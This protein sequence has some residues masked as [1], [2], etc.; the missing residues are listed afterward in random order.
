[1]AQHRD[2][3][4]DTFLAHFVASNNVQLRSRDVDSG[5]K[6]W[7]SRLTV[8][9]PSGDTVLVDLYL[10]VIHSHSRHAHEYRFQGPAN[11]TKRAIKQR[12]NIIP[13]I[14][15]ID[16]SASPHI[17]VAGNAEKYL[18]RDQRQTVLFDVRILD[19]V[20][21]Q[22][23]A[24]YHSSTGETIHSFLPEFFPVFVDMVRQELNLPVYD[25]QRTLR[26][27]GYNESTTKET[28]ERVT[29]AISR[30]LRD[31]KF[32][33]EVVR[34]YQGRCA[35]SDINWGVVQAAHIFPVAA[36]GSTDRISNGIGLTPT[37][38]SLFDRHLIYISPDDLSVRLHP[39]LH[40]DKTTAAREFLKATRAIL[41]VPSN[42]SQQPDPIM[43]KNRY[44]Y[45][46]DAYS[47]ALTPAG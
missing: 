26:D 3:H 6:A 33:K 8:R 24:E 7:P 10:G 12:N 20:R 34:A 9:L 28:R 4:L 31:Y 15:G 47:W 30:L 36:P 25:I 23:W 18:D 43:F 42:A 17:L 11:A 21:H 1:M 2:S 41:R 32:T 29:T 16:G 19:Q 35:L 45:F 40:E 13:I 44:D 38:H 27:A 39:R 46:G 22:G 37:Y 5:P 14:L